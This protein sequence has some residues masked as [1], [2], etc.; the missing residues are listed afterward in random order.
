MIA[1]RRRAPVLGAALAGLLLAGCGA[2]T[3]PADD[4]PALAAGLERVDAAIVSGRYDQARNRLTRLVGV[5]TSAREAGELEQPEADR[6]LAAVAELM[7]AL[8]A[9]QAD[10]PAPSEPATSA[11]P[12]EPPADTAPEVAAPPPDAGTSQPRRRDRSG[13]AGGGN[14]GG[15]ETGSSS[16][17]GNDHA[18]PG[19]GNGNGKAKGKSKGKGKG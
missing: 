9:E 13:K 3:R 1:R 7:S 16:G 5:T 6:I 19:N 18:N 2:S 12:V 17:R 14:R 15:S 8:P 11:P 10:A 4:V